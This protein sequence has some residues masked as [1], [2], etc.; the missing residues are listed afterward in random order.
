MQQAAAVVERLQQGQARA[1][2]AAT[3]SR[4]PVA[5]SQSPAGR[6]VL[7]AA[8]LVGRL[9]AGVQRD[10]AQLRSAQNLRAA[11][12]AAK[13]GSEPVPP[14]CE[15]Q[16]QDEAQPL[17]EA[18]EARVLVNSSLAADV[19]DVTG[20]GPEKLRKRT[21]SLSILASGC[22]DAAELPTTSSGTGAE[23]FQA[24]SAH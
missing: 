20:L 9:H 18:S 16:A 2:A 12:T 21:A 23:S 11:E 1:A 14:V 15:K 19:Q 17:R 4:R 24:P 10:A 13:L 3:A 5:V 6:D 8:A 7:R 22:S